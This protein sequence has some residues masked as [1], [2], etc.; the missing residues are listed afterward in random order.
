MTVW[1]TE[2][3]IFRHFVGY[4]MSNF[5]HQ[6]TF[7]HRMRSPSSTFSDPQMHYFE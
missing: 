6:D 4:F 1:F 3:T 2:T 7:I 5:R